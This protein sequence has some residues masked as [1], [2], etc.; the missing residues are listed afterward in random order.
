MFFPFFRFFFEGSRRKK[1]PAAL[2]Q[3]DGRDA[4]RLRHG[5]G[6][7]TREE[8]GEKEKRSLEEDKQ[9]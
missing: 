1:R 2:R 3:G 6:K 7:T 4:P 8:G 5:L 9:G